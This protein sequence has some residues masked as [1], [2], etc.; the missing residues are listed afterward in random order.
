MLDVII[1]VIVVLLACLGLV[2]L[3]TWAAV[4]YSWKGNRVYKII[5]IG[6]SGK[7]TGDQMSLF[8]ACMQWEANPSRQIYVLYN[9][10]LSEEEIE[11]CV[12][13]TKSTGAIFVKTPQEL[14]A[15]MNN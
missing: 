5:P 11:A 2:Q 10:G 1:W 14:I 6:G 3:C 9:A 7:K 13:L 15:L 4:R 12:Q 8:Y